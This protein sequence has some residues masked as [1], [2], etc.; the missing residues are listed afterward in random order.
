MDEKDTEFPL[1]I[2]LKF[3][4]LQTGW[5]KFNWWKLV[6]VRKILY[7]IPYSPRDQNTAFTSL[8]MPT[9]EY[10]TIEIIE[11]DQL[12]HCSYLCIQHFLALDCARTGLFT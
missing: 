2:P 3:V 7:L 9:D 6:T 1:L 10:N 12:K 11:Q 5:N 4:Q 8:Q